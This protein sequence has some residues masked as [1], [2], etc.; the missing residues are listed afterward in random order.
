MTDETKA[1][2]SETAGPVSDADQIK[3]EAERAAREVAERKARSLDFMENYRD[4]QKAEKEE[5]AKRATSANRA[6]AKAEEE[7]RLREEAERAAKEEA[8]RKEREEFEARAKRNS[9]MLNEIDAEEARRKEEEAAEARQAAAA[10]AVRPAPTEPKAAPVARPDAPRAPITDFFEKEED[11][12]AEDI[13]SA[14]HIDG[15]PIDTARS[16]DGVTIVDLD[17]EEKE[18]ADLA[19]LIEIRSPK[20]ENAPEAPRTAPT[21]EEAAPKAEAAPAYA[22]PDDYMKSWQAAFGQG[23]EGNGTYEEAMKQWQQ[24]YAAA[25]AANPA[26][27]EWA[28]AFGMTSAA[29]QKA[30]A[31]EK[32]ES[33]AAPAAALSEEA[34]LAEKAPPAESTAAPVD[35]LVAD[36]GIDLNAIDSRDMAVEEA[37][38]EKEIEKTEGDVKEEEQVV[39]KAADEDPFAQ[40]LNEQN[41]KIAERRVARK[42]EKLPDK[43]NVQA[44]ICNL[45]F[46]IL[47]EIYR[48]KAKKYRKLYLRGAK[49]ELALFNDMLAKCNKKKKYSVR[50]VL[51]DATIPDRILKG[52]A[53]DALYLEAMKA[54]DPAETARRREKLFS[55]IEGMERTASP[56]DFAR[57]IREQED[58]VKE[59]KAIFKAIPLI[60][61]LA[62]QE[63]VCKIYF[64]ILRQIRLQKKSAY[65]KPYRAK[66][67]NEITIYNELARKVGKSKKTTVQLLTQDIPD[68]LLSGED[69]DPF[70]NNTLQKDLVAAAHDAEQ[71]SEKVEIQDHASVHSA[72][73]APAPIE[74][75]K[76]EESP[77]AKYLAEKEEAIRTTK[78]RF[79]F[80]ELDEQ[81]RI[82]R[83]V[84]TLYFDILW[85]IYLQKKRAYAPTYR[86]LALGEIRLYN[87]LLRRTGKYYE[88]ET[89]PVALDVPKK[90]LRGKM[91]NP[92]RAPDE[93]DEALLIAELPENT[94]LPTVLKQKETDFAYL[95]AKADFEISRCEREYR[96]SQVSFLASDKKK[97]VRKERHRQKKAIKLLKC[98]RKKAERI[99]IYRNGRYYD[100]VE[101]ERSAR[102]RVNVAAARRLREQIK[103]MLLERDRINA[104][105]IELYEYDIWKPAVLKGHPFLSRSLVRTY[106]KEKDAACRRL[107]SEAQSIKKLQ[108]HE[109]KDLELFRILEKKADLQAELA[110]EKKLCRKYKNG[111]AIG[112]LIR[113]YD[114]ESELKKIDVTLAAA[115]R[116]ADFLGRSAKKKKRRGSAAAN[117]GSSAYWIVL[118][119]LII[120]LAVA[121][122]CFKDTIAEWLRTF[123]A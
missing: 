18:D 79:D 27:A 69:F 72:P 10:P 67:K 19:D 20:S 123:L 16:A 106:T 119:L 37:A 22:T 68:R 46:D 118:L 92:F 89:T 101:D 108:L 1:T 57:W 74:Q 58:S 85:Q 9:A 45:Y 70:A 42:K 21:A 95:D 83:R 105:L 96:T 47:H 104:R 41:A 76:P 43:L 82:E 53:P 12:S 116:D 23:A 114:L 103:A 115:L 15:A 71:S 93:I 32:V 38:V 87:S 62:L 50:F 91:T 24:S 52:E 66:A 5:R 80:F 59:K 102:K 39:A 81:I 73:P 97:T 3:A 112:S 117:G 63:S 34:P 25:L 122:F 56:D 98:N 75:K 77:F 36:T 55:D 88:G 60:E 113:V 11:V 33:E 14:V 107:S 13:L 65:K 110:V 86:D 51:A 28:R 35:S 17:D 120:G 78:A 84:C 2:V 48:Y 54:E 30:P 7:K 31:A 99:E 29:V 8:R 90:L 111:S 94:T 4:S 109:E 6:R 100:L 26:Y 64:E 121:A 44:E 61:R 49:R 40:Y